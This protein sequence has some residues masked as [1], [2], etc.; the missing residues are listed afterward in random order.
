MFFQYFVSTPFTPHPTTVLKSL[1]WNIIV[2]CPFTFLLIYF[3]F[4]ISFDVFVFYSFDKYIYTHCNSY[5]IPFFPV[6]CIEFFIVHLF[7]II[8][9]HVFF[10]TNLEKNK[11]LFLKIW[12]I[13]D[14]MFFVYILRF[15]PWVSRIMSSGGTVQRF[16]DMLKLKMHDEF[17][18]WRDFLVI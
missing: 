16:P 12:S 2:T 10:M 13:I 7:K 8:Y 5:F 14:L 11:I 1:V 9:G 17:V 4:R 15:N 6:S 18:A 3:D